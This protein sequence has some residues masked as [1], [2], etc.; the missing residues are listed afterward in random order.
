MEAIPEKYYGRYNHF[1]SYVKKYHLFTFIVSFI[2]V[3]Y[4]SFSNFPALYRLYFVLF[5]TR[6]NVSWSG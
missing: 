2:F 6:S 5:V 4:N 3:V 1:R